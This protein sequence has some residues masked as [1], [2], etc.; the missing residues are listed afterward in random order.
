MKHWI[1]VLFSLTLIFC[2]LGVTELDA[3][4][5]TQREEVQR[6]FGY[7]ILPFR[8]LTLPFDVSVNSNETGV[9]VDIG[10]VYFVFLPLF[11]LLYFTRRK[12]L[13]T[14]FSISLL[15]MWIIG[16]SNSYVNTKKLGQQRGTPEN[17]ENIVSKVTYANEPVAFLTTRIYLGTQE[18]YKPLL[19][20]VQ[21]FSGDSD[22]I[23]YPFLILCFLFGTY[24][25]HRLFN[26]QN[27]RRKSLII[28]Y[29]VLLIF[30]FKYLSLIH[31]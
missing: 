11:L 20:L 17:L 10:S 13:L 8:Y 3:Q 15:L 31:I 2:S 5:N 26:K 19:R 24:L 30:W 22:Y 27:V 4:D 28:I 25:I 7:E 12:L 14:V 1:I 9:Y 21:P 29:W 18:M 6:Y 16:T 23:T